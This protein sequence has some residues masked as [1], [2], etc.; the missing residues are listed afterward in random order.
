MKPQRAL[1]LARLA[2]DERT[3]EHERAAA[4]LALAKLVARDGM[5]EQPRA[6]DGGGRSHAVAELERQNQALAD[7]LQQNSEELKQL[8]TEKR[9]LEEQLRLA[10]ASVNGASSR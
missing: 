3:P 10:R 7:I 9:E 2:A 8:R 4:A 6:W 1:D 5:P